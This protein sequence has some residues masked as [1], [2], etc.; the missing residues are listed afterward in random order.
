MTSWDKRFISIK[1]EVDQALRQGEPI[2]ALESTVITHGLPYPQNRDLAKNMEHTIREKGCI[3]ATIAILDGLIHVGLDSMQLER[4]ARAEGM[5]KISVRDIAPAVV[6]KKSGGTTVAATLAI[7]GEVGIKVFATGGIGGVHRQAPFDVSADLGELAKARLVVVC[8]GSKAILDIPATLEVLETNGVP[9]IGYQTDEFPGFY[10]LS[11]GLGVSA[12]VDSAQEVADLADA[13]WGMGLGGCILVAVPP[14]IE[15]AMQ[16]EL[17]ESAIQAALQEA[18]RMD[19][20]GQGVTPFLLGK[21]N[22]LTGGASLRANLG[23]LVNNAG[24]AAEIARFIRPHFVE[25][26]PPKN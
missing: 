14:P 16:R 22:E 20:R 15:V 21:V 6:L 11:S 10:S 19:I 13:H 18:Q 1:T 2:V 26:Q 8:A 3:P 9:V 4:L 25:Q 7:A 24:V 12:R 5:R 23:L 17:I